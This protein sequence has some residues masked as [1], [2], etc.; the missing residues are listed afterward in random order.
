MVEPPQYFTTSYDPVLFS[1]ITLFPFVAVVP[2]LQKKEKK[3]HYFAVKTSE[4]VPKKLSVVE[5]VLPPAGF[6]DSPDHK[7]GPNAEA[8]GLTGFH[9]A[10]VDQP[11]P[12]DEHLLMASEE[13][14]SAPTLHITQ[15]FQPGE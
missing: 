3:Y 12:Q 14:V 7:P 6:G 9:E 8:D 13:I 11:L 5:P 15:A 10:V 2:K 1:N 4:N